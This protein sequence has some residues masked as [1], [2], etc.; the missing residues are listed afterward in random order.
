MGLDD[1]ALLE[2]IEMLRTADGGDLMRRLLG[3]MLQVVV[4]AEATQRIGA[5]RHGRT[6]ER[7]T[8][9]NGTR[10]KRVTTAAGD[11]TVKI[12][13]LRS[14]SFFPA[15]L[16]PRRRIEVALHAVVMQAY[17]QGV[18]T[19]QV[20]DLVL[21]MGGIGISKSEVSRIC[22]QLD[23]DVAIWRT[24]TLEHIAFPYVSLDATYCKVRINQR[25]I[26]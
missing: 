4:D 5:A 21:A 11:V 6:D 13:K 20:D 7:T 10:D 24:Q 17:V 15:L 25:V 16:E 2:M 22:A 18:S 1:S 14:G 3:G 9:R 8:E 19:R 12:P 23:A 26:S